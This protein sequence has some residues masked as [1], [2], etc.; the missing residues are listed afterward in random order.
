MAKSKPPRK[1]AGTGR[2][3][4]PA[5]L[6]QAQDAMAARNNGAALNMLRP[7]IASGTRDE[8][9]FH[10]AAVAALRLEKY[11]LAASFAR[12]AIAMG[13]QD[14]SHY[15]ALSHA[16]GGMRDWATVQK[17]GLRALTLRDGMV[18]DLPP[19]H[20]PLAAP[21]PDARLD[22]IAFSL[23][24]GQSKYCETAIL[25][26]LEQPNLYPNWRC[27]FYI[28]GTVPPII[29]QRLQA[30]GGEI[31]PVSP[32][33]DAWP[34]PMWRFAA[35][36]DPQARR[37]IFRDADSVISAREAGAVAEWVAQGQGF[38]AMRD[39]GSHTELL[40]AGLWGA[41]AGAL[42][43]MQALI[44]A[45]MQQ[46]VLDAHYA[47]QYF[48]RHYVWPYAR[49]DIL[50]HDSLFG[51]MNPRPFPEGPHRDD[52]HTGYAEGSPYATISTQQPEGSTVYW[53]LMDQRTTPHSPICR[54]PAV[55]A[56]GQVI[57]HLPARYARMLSSGEM[58]IFVERAMPHMDHGPS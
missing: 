37:V 53:C 22:I 40:L 4:V 24:G 29:V 18:P 56:Q 31:V 46:P 27:R 28:D 15:D 43:S 12:Q 35:L 21:Q 16:A 1:S 20:L 9:L 58:S 11:A 26:C 32:P 3:D 47:D 8:Q 23:F 14:F 55:V 34:G 2:R 49:R 6:A 36:D 5:L 10:T 54:Y 30:A 38:H 57:A 52:F 44:S 25:N 17:A 48:L 7:L 39:A 41:R 33:W 19:I 42:P 50:Q 45:Y 13:P 51:F